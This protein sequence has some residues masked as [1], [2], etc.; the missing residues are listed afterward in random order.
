[1]SYNQ[2][3]D[4]TFR[5]NGSVSI[6]GKIAVF[7]QGMDIA[8]DAGV[9]QRDSTGIGESVFTQNGD[10]IGSFSF[11]LKNTT[12]L[13]D[14][15]ATPTLDETLSKWMKAVDDFDPSIITFIQTFNAPKANVNNEARITFTGRVMTPATSLSVDNAVEDANVA[16]EITVFTS[17]QRIIP[18]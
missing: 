8:I 12:D 6:A 14:P 13:Y 1:M 7:V 17:A 2:K 15:A 11:S 9:L 4:R 18:S 10:V 16:G 3:A 5:I